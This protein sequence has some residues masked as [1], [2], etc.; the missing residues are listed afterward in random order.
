[1]THE[2]RRGFGKGKYMIYYD[3]VK[4]Q[5]T[6]QELDGNLE[7]LM[8]RAKKLGAQD[9][10]ITLRKDLTR[11]LTPREMDTNFQ[12]LDLAVKR[13]LY[14]DGPYPA[15]E[16]IFD[17]ATVLPAGLTFSRPSKAWGLRNGEVVEYEIDEPVFE[18]GGL[19]LEPQATNSLSHSTLPTENTYVTSDGFTDVS[20]GTSFVIPEWG[21]KFTVDGE[22]A[23]FGTSTTVSP[24]TLVTAQI[25]VRG[26]TENAEMSI[27][28]HGTTGQHRKIYEFSN[29]AIR[30]KTSTGDFT[31]SEIRSLGGGWEW[32]RLG[33]RTLDSDTDRRLGFTFYGGSTWEVAHI[34]REIGNGI[35]TS[36]I[37]TFGSPATRA[38]DQFQWTGSSFDRAF[39]PHQGA[40]IFKI[41][42]K[43]GLPYIGNTPPYY[44]VAL[45]TESGSLSAAPAA[46][47]WFR[48]SDDG[49][50]NG[51]GV[52]APNESRHNT[53]IP[54][55]IYPD[56]TVGLSWQ[57]ETISLFVNGA[58]AGSF[59]HPD[60]VGA[61]QAVERFHIP[62]AQHM[63][64]ERM[65][66]FST[67]PTAQEMED[68]THA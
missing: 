24:D 13:A 31:H 63:Y 32:V 1:M 22:H 61:L 27:N 66:M 18:F 17:G 38:A 51:I 5:L 36:I 15:A 12:S 43:S 68:L 46:G 50:L 2:Q 29:G 56:D 49:Y 7:Q 52:K 9:M 10:P 47:A 21:Q 42:E 59:T 40:F 30:E 58:L 64:L 25:L 14:G 6:Q 3:T 28:S 54:H 65:S 41:G 26:L 55:N 23:G 45:W 37:P 39:N 57:G 11:P 67:R 4:R 44:G 48:G 33:W 34:Q 19:R 8:L 53:A 20:N 35:P 60:V 62:N 16:Y